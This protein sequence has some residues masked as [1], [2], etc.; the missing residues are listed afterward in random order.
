MAFIG[1]DSDCAGL[2]Q[3]VHVGGNSR[4]TRPVKTTTT[5]QTRIPLD[6]QPTLLLVAIEAFWAR[7]LSTI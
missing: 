2:Q 3:L 7:I 5:V 6:A 4:E 1:V